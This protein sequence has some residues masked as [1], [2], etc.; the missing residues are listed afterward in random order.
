MGG[1]DP[2]KSIHLSSAKPTILGVTASALLSKQPQCA[3]IHGNQP[4]S[5][6]AAAA[7]AGAGGG[8]MGCAEPPHHNIMVHDDYMRSVKS[9]SFGIHERFGL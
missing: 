3:V 6:A 8:A 2:A 7:A 1:E 4:Q 5:A 9:L